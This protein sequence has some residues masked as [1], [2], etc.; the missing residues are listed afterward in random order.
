MD[1]EERTWSTAEILKLHEDLEIKYD[2]G[3]GGDFLFG[4]QSTNP[5]AKELLA[6][7]KRRARNFDYTK[8]AY[9]ESDGELAK[10]VVELHTE[11]DKIV[12][13]A[14]FCAASGGTSVLFALCYW[15][16]RSGIK[17]IYYIPP[18]YFTLLNGLRQFKIRAR[19]L[20]RFHSFEAGFR[21]TLPDKEIVLLIADPVWYA[22]IPV[23]EPIIEQIAEWQQKTGS[24]PAPGLDDTD[25]ANPACRSNSIGLR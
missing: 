7:V 20:S 8:Y 18:I 10:R 21:I 1:K 4:W 13:D 22:G 15:L 9:M 19:P 17:E 11:L 12:P 14:A 16:A 23:P 25:L 6:A 24:W 2:D 3:G 5:F